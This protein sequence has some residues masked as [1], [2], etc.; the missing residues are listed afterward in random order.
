MTLRRAGQRLTAIFLGLVAVQLSIINTHAE[1]FS[2]RT[3]VRTKHAERVR[4]H[5][6]AL[7]HD[8]DKSPTNGA[9]DAING[10]STLLTC[11]EDRLDTL[12]IG[13][14]ERGKFAPSLPGRLV[15]ILMNRSL[16][17]HMDGS[18]RGCAAQVLEFVPDD[19][20]VSWRNPV[21]DATYTVTPRQSYTNRNGDYCRAF[22]TEATI[23]GVVQEANA[24]ACRQDDGAWLVMWFA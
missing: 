18:D 5:A 23:D 21:T 14:T 24:A 7:T 19:H 3:A 2:E 4:E 16:G 22:Q 13:D 10:A 12:L 15:G 11:H 9:S 20:A 17:R 1:S 8:P 6:V